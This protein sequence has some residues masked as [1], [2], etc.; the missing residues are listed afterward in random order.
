M[1]TEFWKSSGWNDL[2]KKMQERKIEKKKRN[3]RKQH[4][5]TCD[6]SQAAFQDHGEEG[7]GK[8]LLAGGADSPSLLTSS[9][10]H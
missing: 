3:K 1:E 2:I 7:L 6:T 8:N 4:K 9:L 5:E 10:F